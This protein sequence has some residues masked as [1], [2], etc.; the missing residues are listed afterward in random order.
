MVG[1]FATC[2][3]YDIFRVFLSNIHLTTSQTSE[4]FLNML[5]RYNYP[6]ITYIHSLKLNNSLRPRLMHT[7]KP[8]LQFTRADSDI[9][10][11][12]S[13]HSRQVRTTQVLGRQKTPNL[14]ANSHGCAFAARSVLMNMLM[15]S[16]A[17]TPL[18]TRPL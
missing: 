14:F 18:R 7:T 12:H 15:P 2:D 1:K 10:R 5:R 16:A 17:I 13:T 3:L 11:P 9:I 4:I 8:Q 6:N